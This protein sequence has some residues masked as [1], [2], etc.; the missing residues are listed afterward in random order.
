M[1]IEN[2]ENKNYVQIVNKTMIRMGKHYLLLYQSLVLFAHKPGPFQ[3]I[4]QF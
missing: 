1:I 3:N 4:I 2:S